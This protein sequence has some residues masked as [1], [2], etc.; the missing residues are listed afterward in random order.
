MRV[1]VMT[2]LFP[3]P[4]HPSLGMFVHK[5][6]RALA[7]MCEVKILSPRTDNVS[8]GREQVGDLDVIRP[9]WW[10]LP[11]VG[12]FVD[13]RTYAAAARRALQQLSPAFDFDVIDSHWLYPDGY[14]AVLLGRRLGRPAVVTGRGTDVNELCFRWPLRR[15]A[16]RTLRGATRLVAVSRPLKDKMVQ[17]GAPPERVAVIHNGIDPTIFRPADDRDAVRRA[18]DLPGGKVVLLS[19]GV[20]VEAKGFQELAAGLALL[21]SEPPVHLFIAG[22]GPYRGA[23][24]QVV[25]EKGVADRVTLLGNVAQKD[26]PRWYQAADLFCFGSWREGCP[27]VVLESLACGTPVVSTS[28]GAVPDLL[29]EERLGVLFAPRSPEAFTTALRQALARGWDRAAIA[30]RGSRRSWNHAAKEYCAVFEQAI[31]ESRSPAHG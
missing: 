8:P 30:V 14:A 18:L 15:L 29:E 20:L 17:A 22:E 23:L 25:R 10:R 5:R 19:V 16:R 31:A 6:T 26:M 21:P 1:L 27:N 4:R 9:R 3:S 28:V 11:K 2:T 7:S 24:E 12:V 13:G